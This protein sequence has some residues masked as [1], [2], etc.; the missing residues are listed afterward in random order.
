MWSKKTF[1]RGTVRFVECRDALMKIWPSL[2]GYKNG[3]IGI[4]SSSLLA[5]KKERGVTCGRTWG[6]YKDYQSSL[7]VRRNLRSGL[8]CFYW[9]TNCSYQWKRQV[10]SI[11]SSEI[12]AS[13][14]KE[15]S[16]IYL[17]IF[18]SK[19]QHCNTTQYKT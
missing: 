9:M 11:G 19:I 17:F 3:S 12:T 6:F 4:A 18:C 14:K 2:D 13:D 8:F 1:L 16:L 7:R 15:A 5:T 10:N